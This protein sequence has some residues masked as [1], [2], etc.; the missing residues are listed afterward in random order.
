M[1]PDAARTRSRRDSCKRATHA[2]AKRQR[3]AACQRTRRRS[4]LSGTRLVEQLAELLES[5]CAVVTHDES[6][7]AVRNALD[8]RGSIAGRRC[9]AG[10]MLEA[11]RFPPFREADTAC[12]T[13]Q[14]LGSHVCQKDGTFSLQFF[15]LPRLLV[16]ARSS[17]V[18]RVSSE[19]TETG[20]CARSQEPPSFSYL[21]DK[22]LN[23]V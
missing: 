3:I 12:W 8:L 7:S 4:A 2:S 14:Q 11:E 10:R 5:Y 21:G 17:V 16:P 22:L 1:Q 6:P 9:R 15:M 19:Q 20:R 13:R 18:R 23:S